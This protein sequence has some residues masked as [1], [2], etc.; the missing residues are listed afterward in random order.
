MMFTQQTT[1]KLNLNWSWLLKVATSMTFC[2]L[3]F[4]TNF[5]QVNAASWWDFQAIDTMKY[6]RDAS[7]EYLSDPAEL[8][9]AADEHVKEIAEV[10]ATHVAIATPYD[11]EFLPVLK[12]WV[13]AARKYNLKVWFRGNWSGWEKWFD[14]PR[15][16]RKQHIE[17]T[18]AFIQQNPDLFENGDYFSACPE[19][20]N[21][22]PGDPRMNGDEAGHRKFL[23]DEHKAMLE[24]FR[25]INKNVQV[26]LNSMNGDVAKLIMNRSTTQALGGKIVVD[27]Y[28]DL[29][30][31]LNNDVTAYA[32]KSGGEVILGEFGAPIPDI[33]GTM[34]EQEQAAWIDEALGLLA[35]NPNIVGMS[36]WTGRGG[37]TS[38]WTDDGDAK[39]GVAILKKYFMPK[40]VRGNITDTAGR[41]LNANLSTPWRTVFSSK[42]TGYEIPYLEDNEQVIISAANHETV[43]MTINELLSNPN[44][45][46]TPEKYTFWYSMKLWWYSWFK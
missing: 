25:A 14:Y 1:T 6:S 36:Y 43:E 41:T 24:A 10:G 30:E 27:H 42:E 18:I 3:L 13:A 9:K 38:V 8:Q 33:N 15:I 23:I 37:S 32:K 21:G 2:S 22:G 19:C 40:T 31:D 5:K 45:H 26:N 7:R 29:P 34:T 39:A 35:V 44:I 4:M 11:E 17:K 28:V 20:E 46:L 12:E 16:T